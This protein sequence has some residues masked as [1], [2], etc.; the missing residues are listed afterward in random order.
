MHGKEIRIEFEH[1]QTDAYD[2]MRAET[3]TVPADL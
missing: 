2:V 1:L 3:H